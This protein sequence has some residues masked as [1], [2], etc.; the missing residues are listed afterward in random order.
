[1]ESVLE[2]LWSEPAL[3]SH[4]N[5]TRKNLDQLRDEGLPFIRANM[6]TRLYRDDAL[7]EFL[8]A[9]EIV[10]DYAPKVRKVKE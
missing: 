6:R 4:L 5:L 7:Y 3:L 10:H 8:V 1:M 9:R 2:K